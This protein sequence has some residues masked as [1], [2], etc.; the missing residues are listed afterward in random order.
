M[1]NDGTAV[2]SRVAAKLLSF[3]KVERAKVPVNVYSTLYE[4]FS[5]E[6][7]DTPQVAVL[8]VSGMQ[9]YEVP[10]DEAKEREW[11]AMIGA[12]KS[13]A[14]HMVGKLKTTV[15]MV[16]IPFVLYNGQLSGRIDTHLWGTVLIMGASILTIWSMIYYMQKA[17]PE[18]RAR[19]K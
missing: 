2:I 10:G 11:M 16:A 9:I 18:I 3:G 6:V 4:E 12:N 15:Q 13:V 17:L 1:T 8:S 19:V 14:V 7:D 5:D